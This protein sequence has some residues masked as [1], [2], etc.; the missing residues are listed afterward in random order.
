MNPSGL[1]TNPTNARFD[2]ESV[3]LSRDGKSIFVSDEYGPYIYRFDRESGLRT[4]V[5]TL[6]DK[7]A[8]SFLSSQGDLEI[9]FANNPIGRIANKGM[10]GLA[11]TPDGSTLVGIMQSALEQDGGDD[12]GQVLRIVTIDVETGAILHEKDVVG[13]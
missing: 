6:P 10:E 12:I 8:I 9:D 5:Y 4:A 13:H 1:L 7:F 2:P 3:R 11:I